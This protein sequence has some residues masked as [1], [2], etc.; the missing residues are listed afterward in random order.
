MGC[1][2]LIACYATTGQQLKEC[3]VPDT[4]TFVERIGSTIRETRSSKGDVVAAVR[5]VT[6]GFEI[7]KGK[8]VD[9][10][11]R[12]E[13]GFARGEATFEAVDE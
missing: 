13:R 2:A 10:E 11:R 1:T 8:I 12:T 3:A 7:F 6:G 9:V 4:I 5:E